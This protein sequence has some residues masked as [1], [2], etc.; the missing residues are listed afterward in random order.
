MT[1]YAAIVEKYQSQLAKA[2]DRFEYS[3]RK[4]QNRPSFLGR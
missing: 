3:H 1:D 2:L 4:T